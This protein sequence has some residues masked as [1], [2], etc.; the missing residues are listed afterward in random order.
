M[1]PN[2][3]LTW[4]D[5]INTAGFPGVI[6]AQVALGWWLIKKYAPV[7]LQYYNRHIVALEKQNDLMAEVATTIKECQRNVT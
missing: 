5:V 4:W 7:L 1:E 2:E 6:L 3:A